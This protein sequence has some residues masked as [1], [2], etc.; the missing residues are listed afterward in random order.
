MV[1]ETIITSLQNSIARGE[2]LTNAK[3]IMIN[4]GYD[5]SE[6]EEASHYMGGNIT[7][8]FQPRESE[9]FITPGQK[10][11]LQKPYMQN[12]NAFQNRQLPSQNPTFLQQNQYLSNNQLLPQTQP[13]QNSTKEQSLAQ[14][15]RQMQ[16]PRKS[17][18]TEIILTII[19]LFLIGIL[20]TTFVFKDQILDFLS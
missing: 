16:K 3:Q 18:T 5:S 1:N 2:S 12:Q 13:L 6:V 17:Y 15:E 11:V 8:N 4:S 19:L 20:I 7:Q 10:G 14:K 9:Q